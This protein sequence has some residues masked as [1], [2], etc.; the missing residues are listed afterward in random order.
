MKLNLE[1]SEIKELFRTIRLEDERLAPP[2]HRD[3]VSGTEKNP[4]A[5]T[6]YRFNVLVSAFAAVL[7]LVSGGL[8]VSGI[9]RSATLSRTTETQF[10]EPANQSVSVGESLSSEPTIN[11]VLSSDLS[12]RQPRVAARRSDGMQPS[13]AG[14]RRQPAGLRRSDFSISR[15][16]P[17]TNFLLRIADRRMLSTVPSFG[18]PAVDSKIISF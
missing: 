7:I 3:R 5:R 11:R 14:T 13:R 8:I 15:W 12:R 6:D 1:E 18:I 17:P 10:P 4:T 2:F 16:E 9:M